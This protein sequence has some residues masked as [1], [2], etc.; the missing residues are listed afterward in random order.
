MGPVE[1]ARPGCL[2]LQDISPEIP[3]AQAGQ[4]ACQHLR[5]IQDRDAIQGARRSRLAGAIGRLL[6]F[7]LLPISITNAIMGYRKLL[8]NYGR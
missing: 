3:Q 7:P 8:V 5:A 6:Q 1:L 2:D 4:R